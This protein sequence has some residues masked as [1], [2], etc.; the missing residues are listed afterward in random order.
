MTALIVIED[1]E[2]KL[3]RPQWQPGQYRHITFSVMKSSHGRLPSY[4]WN[5][6][7]IAKFNICKI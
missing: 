7:K 2:T 6:N 3:Q 5:K 1:A 4:I